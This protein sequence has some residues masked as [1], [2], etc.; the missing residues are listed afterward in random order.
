MSGRGIKGIGSSHRRIYI[1]NTVDI[2]KLS[3]IVDYGC[4]ELF[5]S[6]IY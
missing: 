1:C 3:E 4:Y 5:L 6:S 2:P